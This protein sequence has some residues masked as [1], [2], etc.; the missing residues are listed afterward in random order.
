MRRLEESG[1]EIRLLVVGHID[2]GGPVVGVSLRAGWFHLAE[3]PGI[4]ALRSFFRVPISPTLRAIQPVRRSQAAVWRLRDE[5]FD[6][7]MAQ[8]APVGNLRRLTALIRGRP[9][10]GP[11]HDREVR[12]SPLLRPVGQR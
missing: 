10:D 8:A 4:V 1:F 6:R 12:R 11:V 9:V 7:P 3:M 2:P 5:G